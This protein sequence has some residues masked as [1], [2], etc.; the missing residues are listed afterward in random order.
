VSCPG[1]VPGGFGWLDD[2]T[3]SCA[4]DIV[5]NEFVTITT[6]NTGK[7]TLSDAELNSA[8]SQLG[9]NLSAAP[10]NSSNE[11]KLFYCFVGSTVYVPVYAQAS[12][13]T[14]PNSG[15]KAYCITK[16]AVFQVIGVHLKDNG[17]SQVD[18]CIQ[19]GEPNYDTHCASSMP[20]NWGTLGFYGRFIAYTTLQPDWFLGST[21]AAVGLI[22]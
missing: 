8:V 16:F 4:K 7:C 10:K 20:N 14:G 1:S 19:P 21:H 6:G 18:Y 15:S 2:D 9:C 11:S 13:C 17:S 5:L 22:N 12:N 3:Q